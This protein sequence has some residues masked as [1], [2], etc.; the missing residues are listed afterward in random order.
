M[1]K[2][3]EP[4]NHKH[5]VILQ[6]WANSC[7]FLFWGRVK[8][9]T[10]V[11]GD[12]L[13]RAGGPRAHHCPADDDPRPRSSLGTL[14]STYRR[15]GLSR[16]QWWTSC[17]MVPYNHTSI[18]FLVV[19]AI[20]HNG[21][22]ETVNSNPTQGILSPPPS[23]PSTAGVSTG[24]PPIHYLVPLHLLGDLRSSAVVE[25]ASSTVRHRRTTTASASS[26][27]NPAAP[28]AGPPCVVILWFCVT[29]Y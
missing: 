15:E 21:F 6:T 5:A 2:P 26:E 25:Y 9:D 12:T 14:E 27:E 22:E 23:Y 7:S 8:K 13:R 19:S 17:F 10:T 18:R 24:P 11:P 4:K 1:F 29:K 28:A 16:I 20:M 3:L